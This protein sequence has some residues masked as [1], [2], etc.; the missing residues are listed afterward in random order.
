M[1]DLQQ[2]IGAGAWGERWVGEVSRDK[3]IDSCEAKGR[4][5]PVTEVWA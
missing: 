1:A 4:E 3:I 2:F 5:Q